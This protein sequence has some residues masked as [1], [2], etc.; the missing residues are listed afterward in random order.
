MLCW[1]HLPRF[2]IDIESGKVCD[3]ALPTVN[4]NRHTPFSGC[5]DVTSWKPPPNPI[6]PDLSLIPFIRIP[7]AIAVERWTTMDSH[8]KFEWSVSFVRRLFRIVG[9]DIFQPTFQ[10][11]KWF[12]AVMAFS[13]LTIVFPS[14]CIVNHVGARKW[15]DVALLGSASQVRN[16]NVRI[17]YG[18]KLEL[19][20]SAASG[21]VSVVEHSQPNDTNRR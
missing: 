2:P 13:L 14:I 11:S 4:C 15:M 19:W 17:W 21:K 7:K 5:M 12:Y 8:G 9:Q 1:G 16:T 6:V 18:Y 3:S 10:R 20:Q